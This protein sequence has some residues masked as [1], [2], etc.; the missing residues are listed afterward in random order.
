MHRWTNYRHDERIYEGTKDLPV[1]N[2][3]ISPKGGI[4]KFWPENLLFLLLGINID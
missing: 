1:A 4:S 2:L 3:V